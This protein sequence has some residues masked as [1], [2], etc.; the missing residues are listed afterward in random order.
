MPINSQIMLVDGVMAR[1]V[2][3]VRRGLEA[4]MGAHRGDPQSVDVPLKGRDVTKRVALVPEPL[5]GDT[6]PGIARRCPRR[7]SSTGR[8]GLRSRGSGDSTALRG[9]SRVER[10]DDDEPCRRAA[11]D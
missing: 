4:V 2:G 3:D 9:L 7:R 8:R 10:V 1:H 6:D 11:A 5:G